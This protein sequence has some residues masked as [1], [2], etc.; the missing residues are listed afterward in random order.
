MIKYKVISIKTR[1]KVKV[2]PITSVILHCSEVIA[3][4]QENKVRHI[5]IGNL[6]AK[7]LLLIHDITYAWK[8]QEI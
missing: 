3:F 8:N 6:E 2:L 7:L 4:R 5:N 1:S